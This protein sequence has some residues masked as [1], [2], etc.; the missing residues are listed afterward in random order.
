[1]RD[2]LRHV[3]QFIVAVIDVWG[4]L[5]SG[6]VLVGLVVVSE[7]FAGR[8]ISGWPLWTAIILSIVAA[9]FSAWRK[10]RQKWERLGGLSLLSVT[11]DEMIS[12]YSDRTTAQGSKLAKIYEGK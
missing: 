12:V 6:G 9:F 2:W 3:G 8:S 11:P 4:V 5:V 1:M 7:H 10:E